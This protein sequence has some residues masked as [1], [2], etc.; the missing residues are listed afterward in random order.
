VEGPIIRHLQGQDE[1][2]TLV[3]LLRVL[4]CRYDNKETVISL[5]EMEAVLNGTKGAIIIEP[6]QDGISICMID[7]GRDDNAGQA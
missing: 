7:M 2:A 1:R 4:I 6:V 5:D 3:N